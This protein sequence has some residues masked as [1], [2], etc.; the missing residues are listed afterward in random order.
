MGRLDLNPHYWQ[1]K[2]KRWLERAEYAS[3][4]LSALGTVAA[5]VSQ[6]IAYATTP[7]VLALSLNVINRQRSLFLQTQSLQLLAS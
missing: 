1:M 7:L 4:G 3:L 2:A 6:Q 5:A